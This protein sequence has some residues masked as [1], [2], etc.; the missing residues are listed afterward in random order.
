MVYWRMRLK[1]IMGIEDHILNDFCVTLF[2]PMLSICQQGTAVD[3]KM[4]YQVQGC[5]DL[6]W[7]DE[8]DMLMG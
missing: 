5:C 8:D 3:I 6:E 4:G 1:E 2:C 7:A